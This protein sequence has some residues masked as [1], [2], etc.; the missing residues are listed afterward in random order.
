M[1]NYLHAN[2]NVEVK[3]KYKV[4]SRLFTDKNN[5]CFACGRDNQH[6]LK[7]KEF[8]ISD[9]W[10]YCDISLDHDF[11]GFPGIVHGGIQSTILDELMA[12]AIFVFE[13]SVG[14][15]IDMQIKFR[16]PLPV[17]RPFR[18]KARIESKTSKILRIRSQICIEDDL[19]TEGS[20]HYVILSPDKAR[21]IFGEDVDFQ[22]YKIE[23]AEE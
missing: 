18:A 2:V 8:R 10:I 23:L 11:S 5:R 20:A 4:V 9:G 7:L 15:T 21:K 17:N 16:M 19:Y 22:D 1:D 13:K 12:W 3:G 6:G 14:I